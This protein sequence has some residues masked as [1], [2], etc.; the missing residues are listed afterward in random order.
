MSD[1]RIYLQGHIDVPPDRRQAVADAL[2]LH[3][4]LTLAEPGCMAFEVLPS[5]DVDGRY[6][7][8]EIFSDQA[9][10]DA[11]QQRIKSS[12]WFVVTQ[13]IP[14]DYRIRKGE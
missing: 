5:P 7:V 6:L 3:I 12:E 2:P 4:E 11:H 1:E 10:F 8:S 14:R 9:A 13:G